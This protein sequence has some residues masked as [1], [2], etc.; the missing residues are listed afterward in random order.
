[1][2]F[3]GSAAGSTAGSAPPV[4]S[5][6]I[7]IETANLAT[8]DPRRLR[9]SL[10]SIASQDPSPAQAREVILL[11]CGEAPRELLDNLQTR[12]PWLV[13]QRVSAGTDYGDQ[14]ALAVSQGSG[15]IV[16]FAD[17]D[18]LYE[19][20]WLAALLEAFAARSDVNVLAGETAV[21]IAGPFTLAMAL[22]FFFPRFSYQADVAPARGFYGNN[23]A[24]RRDVFAVCPFPSGLPIYRGQNVI[25]S[26]ILRR[27]GVPIWRQ[28][29]ARSEHSPPEGVGSAIL[30]FFL[31]GRDTPRLARLLP[32]EADAPFQGD[33]EPYGRQG[34]RIR[35][36]LE[37]L[38]AIGRQQ[39][40]SL[41][42][43]PLA[44]PI[45]A[46]CV[47]SF[48]AGVAVE[49]LRPARVYEVDRTPARGAAATS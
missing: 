13:V 45:A 17:S 19:P 8:A 29:H 25:Y 27:A 41:L 4:P 37:R 39:P 35:K 34:G 28:P 44:L 42:L 36:V 10:D 33:Y 12:Y 23:V 1:M 7:V 5:F 26:R 30:R 32:T 11:D 2:P 31:T 20:R 9:A 15:E 3:A 49:R 48:F 38:R 14:K 22:V 24:F 43:L 40:F 18:C 6:S 46:L 16:V 47:A 21:L